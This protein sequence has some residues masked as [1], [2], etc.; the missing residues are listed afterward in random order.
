MDLAP[1]MSKRLG[2]G[3]CTYFS[4]SRTIFCLV[5][6]YANSRNGALVPCNFTLEKLQGNGK[7][8]VE[9]LQRVGFDD[10]EPP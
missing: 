6:S 1:S 5:K 7:L 10:A 4:N 8:R 3:S 2:N 9:G